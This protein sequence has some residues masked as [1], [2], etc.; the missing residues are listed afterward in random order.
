MAV[1]APSHP[2]SDSP[3]RRRVP[4]LILLCMAIA[5]LLALV[6]CLAPW[7]AP[8]DYSVI[9]LRAR[10]VPPAW[11]P[12]GTAAHLLGTDELGRDMLSRLIQSIRTS[13]TVALLGSVMSAV[14]GTF[15]GFLS[16]HF[17]GW[18]DELVMAAVDIQAALPFMILALAVVA[19]FCASMVMFVAL[20]VV[21]G[22]DGYGCLTSRINCVVQ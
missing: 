16:A 22:W 20:L 6:A 21:Y 7:I 1:D 19:F 8:Y 5:I 10:L 18:L 14:L 9:D 12:K 11:Y 3:T 2:L 4:L 15:L 17:R 13:L